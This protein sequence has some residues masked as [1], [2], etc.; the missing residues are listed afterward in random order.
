M[1]RLIRPLLFLLPPERSHRLAMG[2]LWL[3]LR[4]PALGPWF[5]AR[6]QVRSPRLQQTLWGIPFANPV[7]LAAGF[8]KDAAHH[9][10]LASLGFGFIEVGTVTAHSQPGNPRPRLFR[11]PADRAL[12]N[13]M[14]FNN[15]GAEVAARR[16]AATPPRGPLGVNIGRSKVVPNEQA[17]D[18][19]LASL[20]RL[21]RFA[22]YVAVNVSSPNTPEL[23]HL[24]A[25][26]HL[27]PLLRALR[28]GLRELAREAGAPA[29]PLLV[30]IAPDLD[31]REIDDIA[32]VVRDLGIDGVICSNTTV[33]RA[34]GAGD[35]L[36]TPAEQLE[37]I[38]AGGL[39]GRPLR[40]RPERLI[41]RIRRRLGPQIPIIGVG[42]VFDAS[43]AWR[44]IGAGANLVQVYTG[45]IY[46]G[47]AMV[48]DINRGL[49]ARLDAHG[50]DHIEQS[51]GHDARPQPSAP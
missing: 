4:I 13:R 49:L 7:G 35:A 16:L 27:G 41:R 37:A 10:D 51:V 39:S 38:G 44:L 18:D 45:L 34:D 31:D 19:Y 29:P 42:A 5:A 50:F 2:A 40:G 1:Y 32:D 22:S 43:D 33:S 28:D 24:Q 11:L 21:W 9:A 17:I 15:Q 46:A 47:P 36:R 48:R 30:K 23:R 20:R 26:E 12:I 3:L 14:G 8:D 25:A 6:Y